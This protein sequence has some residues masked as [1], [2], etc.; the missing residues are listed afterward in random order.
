MVYGPGQRDIKK[1]VPYVIVSLLSGKSPRLGPGMRPVDWVYVYDVAEG[2]VRASLAPGVV[3][4]SVD[5]GT[6]EMTLV[7]TVVERLAAIIKSGAAPLIGALPDRPLEQ[8]RIADPV[9]TEAALGFAPETP[10]DTGLR[11]T[12]EVVPRQ[13]AHQ[14]D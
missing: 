3:G 1:L 10:L 11:Q 9:A 8:V 6:G 12:V 2:L 7:R 5:L 4:K 14:R 13:A